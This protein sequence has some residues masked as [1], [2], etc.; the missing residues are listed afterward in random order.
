MKVDG[1]VEEIL[2]LMM[3]MVPMVRDVRE[4]DE[5]KLEKEW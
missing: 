2:V 4:D 1:D 5:G 3:T